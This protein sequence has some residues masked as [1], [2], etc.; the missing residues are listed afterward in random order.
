M[1]EQSAKIIFNVTFIWIFL[2]HTTLYIISDIKPCYFW[3]TNSYSRKSEER[4]TQS[5]RILG[6]TFCDF[7][8]LSRGEGDLRETKSPPPMCVLECGA[9]CS[10]F[11]YVTTFLITCPGILYNMALKTRGHSKGIHRL[12]NITPTLVFSRYFVVV[13]NVANDILY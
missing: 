6:P 1:Y 3:S 7:R 13:L 8:T 10:Q 9:I 12:I 2:L 5:Q 11:L 4:L